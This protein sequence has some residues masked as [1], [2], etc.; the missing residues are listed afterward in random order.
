MISRAPAALALLT[1]AACGP[2]GAG[3][4]DATGDG[5]VVLSAIRTYWPLGGAPVEEA[6]DLSAEYERLEIVAV[7]ERC[8]GVWID[9]R[10]E[11]DAPEG[12]YRLRLR[13]APD[14]RARRAGAARRL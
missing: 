14:V 4:S 7:G 1:L 13:R 2:D 8:P 11:F 10:F 12:P 3:D 9:D 5:P 6:R